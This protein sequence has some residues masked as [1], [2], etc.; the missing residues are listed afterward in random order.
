MHRR[1]S[2]G[3]RSGV[4]LSLL[5]AATLG[6]AAPAL[7]AEQTILGSKLS[8]KNRGDASKRQV[9]LG[10]KETSSPNTLVGDPT[11]TGAVLE[12]S[13]NGT[14]PSAQ[15]F[16]LPQGT[17]PSGNDFWSGSTDQGFRYSDKDGANGPVRS[18]QIRRSSNGTFS[19]K[20]KLS[21]KTGTINIL[22]PN[23]G[24]DGCAALELA[25]GDRYS[26]AFGPGSQLSNSGIEAFAAK[27]PT[28]EAECSPLPTTTTTTSTTTTLEG[29]S[30]STAGVLCTYSRS[31]F[32]SD[33]SV[34]ATSNSTWTC[35]ATTRSLSANGIPDHE[36]GTFPNPDCPNAVATQSV[37]RAFTLT[38]EIVSSTGTA[39]TI[40]GYGLNGV[41]FDPNTAGTCNDAGTS[42][43][44]AGGTGAWK[45]EALGQ[46]SFD[47]GDDGNHAHVQPGG[48]YHYHGMPELWLSELGAGVEMTLLGWAVDGFPVYARYGYT[49]AE[50][51]GSPLK[52]L[53]GSWQVRASPDAGRPS[54]GLY[55][56][57]TFQQD[58]EYV[59]GSGDL[60]E[61]NGRYGVTPEFPG[62]IYYYAITDT[63]P[64]FQRCIKGTAMGGPPPP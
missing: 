8:L 5:A 13:V 47:F 55:P 36:I 43:S 45:I 46:S 26:V 42:C 38:P 10:A 63:Y 52:V 24:T 14:S 28:T 35:S 50:D 41:K 58:Y 4:A 22:P 31:V 44:L 33:E 2:P 27:N 39:T 17:A 25:G 7:G 1:V 21:G 19:I 59:P 15:T 48:A 23:T 60:D 61:C 57:G 32:N 12:I 64:Y 29:G 62:G 34:N 30:G 11:A 9:L 53:T 49:D 56:M 51:A 6:S 54:T 3:L 16:L 37:S 40:V 20:A 18:V